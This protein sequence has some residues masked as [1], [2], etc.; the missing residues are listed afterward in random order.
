MKAPFFLHL[1]RLRSRLYETTNHTNC[2]L[3]RLACKY[4]KYSPEN[5]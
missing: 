3:L 4:V 1:E 5:H 2:N